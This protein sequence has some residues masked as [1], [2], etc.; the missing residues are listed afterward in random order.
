MG[1]VD[2]SFLV[3]LGLSVAVGLWRG[4]VYEVLALGGDYQVVVGY[5]N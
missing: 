4:L 3:V 2:L 1:W 5:A